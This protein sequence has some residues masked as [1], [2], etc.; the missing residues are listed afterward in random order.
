MRS[1]SLLIT[2]LAFVCAVLPRAQSP[3]PQPLTFVRAIELPRVDGRL[4]HLAVDRSGR[5]FVAALGNSTVE[6]LDVAKGVHVR[7]L[8]NFREPQGIAVAEGQ[9][10]VVVAEGQGAGLQLVDAS[11]LERG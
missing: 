7:S 5:L 6:V 8:P 1:P 4:D 3:A 9:N 2:V 11:T 10:A